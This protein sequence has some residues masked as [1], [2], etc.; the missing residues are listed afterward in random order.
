MPVRI[1]EDGSESIRVK[2]EAERDPSLDMVI[3]FDPTNPDHLAVMIALDKIIKT[4]YVARTAP[5]P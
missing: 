4:E 1:P 3:E 2:G 5:A